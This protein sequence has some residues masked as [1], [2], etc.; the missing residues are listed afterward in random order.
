MRTNW[1]ITFILIIIGILYFT[2]GVKPVEAATMSTPKYFGITELR[3]LSTPHLGYAIGDPGTNGVTGD[4]A[5]L[6]NIREYS[7]ST[8][9]DPKEVNVYCVKAGVGF[10]DGV[11][12]IAEYNLSFDMYKD[13]VSIAAQNNTLKGLIDGGHRSEERRVGK[14]CRSRWSPYH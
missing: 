14:E 12:K 5:K 9:N 2:I 3:T 10:M 4:A 11:N 8:S 13:K 1:K 6:W 7:S